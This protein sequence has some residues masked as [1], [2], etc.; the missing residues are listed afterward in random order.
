M[1]KTNELTEKQVKEYCRKRDLMIV[2]ADM[3]H[4]LQ[5]VGQK[6]ATNQ[7]TKETKTVLEAKNEKL[8][9]RNIILS[10]NV[11]NLEAEA[12]SLRFRYENMKKLLNQFI[13]TGLIPSYFD[14][15]NQLCQT[16][17]ELKNA[18]KETAAANKRY[19]QLK[20]EFDQYR[21]KHTD[22]DCNCHIQELERDIDL[23]K[24]QIAALELNF[25]E[26]KKEHPEKQV[27]PKCENCSFSY[28][29]TAYDG[30]DAMYCRASEDEHTYVSD[31]HSCPRFKPKE[32][33]NGADL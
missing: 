10:A 17:G 21:N 32:K 19:K 5:L 13:A 28:I 9:C 15:Y 33:D 1:E 27:D 31:T 14:I 3:V 11:Q 26:Y 23:Y 2:S 20:K 29:D 4:R 8:T 22:S 16:K 18:R 6:F 24:S 30:T 12:G 25:E 7:L